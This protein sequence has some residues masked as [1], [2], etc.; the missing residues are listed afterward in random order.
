MQRYKDLHHTSSAPRNCNIST[1][2][3]IP[4]GF[5]FWRHEV[6]WEQPQLNHRTEEKQ[7][8]DCGDGSFFLLIKQDWNALRIQISL[9]HCAADKSAKVIYWFANKRFLARFSQKALILSKV[10]NQVK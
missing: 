4:S 6:H 9:Q 3:M 1:K 2:S 5:W 7:T 10:Y 8:P